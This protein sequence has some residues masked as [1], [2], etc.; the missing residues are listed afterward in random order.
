[1][2]MTK[3]E[4]F[5][6]QALCQCQKLDIPHGGKIIPE[7]VMAEGVAVAFIKISLCCLILIHDSQVTVDTVD[8]FLY[9]RFIKM[10]LGIL[11]RGS[12]FQQF[13]GTIVK[14]PQK[15]RQL[16]PDRKRK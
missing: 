11:K 2:G 5:G 10:L 7:L 6:I 16:N 13:I 4:S 15:E 9:H 12:C 8:G 1:M 14:N 3:K